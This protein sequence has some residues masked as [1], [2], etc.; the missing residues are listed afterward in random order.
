MMIRSLLSILIL[1]AKGAKNKQNAPSQPAQ[2]EQILSV[3]PPEFGRLPALSVHNGD[4]RRG[5]CLPAALH[6]DLHRPSPLCHPHGSTSPLQSLMADTVPCFPHPVKE[7]NLQ[8]WQY[9]FIHSGK[10]PVDTKKPRLSA[11]LPGVCC[12]CFRREK[13]HRVLPLCWFLYYRKFKKKS[14]TLC[15]QIMNN[16]LNLKY[17]Y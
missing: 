17:L 7:E 13:S 11:G 10:Q 16:S 15:K 6:R 3:V 12:V 1:L 9:M 14:C 4:F 8:S 5:I 2:G